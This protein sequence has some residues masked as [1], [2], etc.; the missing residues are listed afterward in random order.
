MFYFMVF[1]IAMLFQV[2]ISHTK[3]TE[4]LEDL[5]DR[6]SW[7]DWKYIFKLATSKIVMF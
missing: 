7:R 3:V 4:I 6:L 1:D 5:D 2:Q